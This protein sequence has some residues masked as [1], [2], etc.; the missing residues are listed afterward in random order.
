MS[1][2]SRCRRWLPLVCCVSAGTVT[3]CQNCISPYQS[4]LNN[5]DLSYVARALQVRPTD[6]CPLQAR[7]A[8]VTCKMIAWHTVSLL[9]CSQA[10]G[11]STAFSSPDLVATIFLPKNEAFTNLVSLTGMT[12]DQALA[13]ESTFAP[14]L[15]QVET[16]SPA[17]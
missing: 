7:Q 6:G 17:P 13:S 3:H 9:C 4:A 10:T 1:W 8:P 12:V 11:L 16:W 2:T 5:A 14:F 15:G